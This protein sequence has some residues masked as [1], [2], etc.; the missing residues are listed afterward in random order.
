MRLMNT[1]QY[2]FILAPYTPAVTAEDIIR[3]YNLDK[4]TWTNKGF[5][6]VLHTFFPV[7]QSPLVPLRKYYG[8]SHTICVFF[9]Q[10]DLGN[11]YWNDR[12]MKRLRDSFIAKVNKRPTFLKTWLALWHRLLKRFQQ[13]LPACDVDLTGLSDLELLNLYKK[14]NAAYTEEYGVAI[15]IQDAFSMHADRFF[16]PALRKFLVLQETDRRFEDIFGILTT[17][18]NESFITAE[19]RERLQ[20]VSFIRKDKKLSAERGT[21][22]EFK[23][24][25]SELPA[26]QKK[27]IAHKQRW[28][29]IGN[30]Y[31]VQKVLGEG[32]F[33]E[34]IVECL[35]T[36]NEKKEL[37]ELKQRAQKAKRVKVALV[38]KLRLS[39]ELRNLVRITEVF[40]YMQDERK[41]YVMIANHY[42]RRFFEEIGRRTGLTAKEMEFTVL[43]EME[44]ILL[45]KKFD[46][47]LLAERRKHCCCIETLKGYEIFTGS[48]AD[49]LFDTL[50]DQ[51]PTD[52]SITGICASRGVIQG[53]VKVVHKISE[54][55]KVEKGDILVASMTRPEM[56]VAMEKAAAIVTDEGGITSHAAIVSRELGIP[57]IVGTKTATRLLKDGD[58]VE[59]DAEKGTVRKI[60]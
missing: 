16:M 14:F 40:A 27:L 46:R 34:K 54:L 38:K 25:L 55:A 41:K 20:L 10:D 33:L 48:I 7:G 45:R 36:I 12:D 26:L 56:V 1:V 57:C 9:F 6:G 21:L 19:Y 44:D 2:L 51:K 60:Q 22:D 15:G 30:N 50:F 13:V 11:W 37:A 58:M 29:W 32:Y 4:S 31:A 5:H 39:K 35:K 3:R 24:K 23:K 17:P 8:D 42:I 28:Y 18:I 59:V 52:G 49:A 43:P 53:I 47:K